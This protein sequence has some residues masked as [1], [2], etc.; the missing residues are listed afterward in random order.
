MKAPNWIL[1]AAVAASLNAALLAAQDK[2]PTL[3]V[4]DPAP[5][6]QTGQWVQGEPVKSFDKGKAYIVE[7]WATWCGPCRVSI[8]HL[9]EIHEKYKDKG[10]IVIGQNC[11][12]RDESKVAPFI[13]TMGKKM[14]YRVAMDDKT[15]SSRGKMAETWMTAAG[16][17]GIPSAFLVDT[18][19]RIAWIGH[20]MQLKEDVIEKVLAGKFDVQKAA[21]DYAREKKNTAALN[22]AWGELNQAVRAK[23]WPAA[24]AKLAEAEPLLPEGSKDAAAFM[25]FNIELGKGD[26][27]AAQKT[28]SGISEKNPDNAGIQNQ[29]AWR[30]LSDKSL[31]DLDLDLAEKIALRANSAAKGKDAGIL[32]TLARAQFMN[33]KKA[34]AIDTQ[35]LAVKAANDD[36]KDGLQKTLDSY[37]KGEL[38]DVGDE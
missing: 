31:K 26:S 16:Q 6:L 5:P 38:P 28:A 14:T 22:K 33:G 29:I 36:T 1:A 11:W 8:P 34:Q 13:Q 32:D 2:A 24:E 4:G 7:F 19:G 3:K 15:G 18:E 10:L 27:A 37:K 23:D 20:P 9:N 17:N 21:A 25:R 35:E 12:E 30:L